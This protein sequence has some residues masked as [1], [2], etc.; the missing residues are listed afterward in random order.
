MPQI[1]PENTSWVGYWMSR[2][3]KEGGV[4]KKHWC[5]LS[6]L[7]SANAFAD[8]GLLS[9][10]AVIQ[11]GCAMVTKG[12]MTM[13]AIYQDNTG[14]SMVIGNDILHLTPE[15]QTIPAFAVRINDVVYY[16]QMTVDDMTINNNTTTK[17][18]VKLDGQDYSIHDNIILGE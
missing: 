3:N 18:R 15:R 1:N 12:T 8:S 6:L 10:N 9:P 16:A 13:R 14:V 11:H 5:F 2:N 7:L 17:L 4:Y